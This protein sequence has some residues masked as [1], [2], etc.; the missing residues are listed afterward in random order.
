MVVMV[1][2]TVEGIGV[3]VGSPGLAAAVAVKS[4]AAWAVAVMARSDFA[5]AVISFAACAVAVWRAWRLAIPSP[6]ILIW[7]LSS[8]YSIVQ[9]AEKVDQSIFSLANRTKRLTNLAR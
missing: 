3:G 5:V 8:L 1:P 7:V 6:R 2:L 4:R 9:P